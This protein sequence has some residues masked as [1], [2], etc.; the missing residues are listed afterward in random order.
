MHSTLAP[1]D[2]PVTRHGHEQEISVSRRRAAASEAAMA[3]GTL[4]PD[5][6]ALI[7]DVGGHLDAFLSALQGLGVDT[8]RGH[9]PP[10]LLVVQVGDL[11]HRGPESTG[12]VQLADRL[13]HHSDDRY[14][15]LLGNHEAFYLGGPRFRVRDDLT[16]KADHTVQRWWLDRRARLAVALSTAEYGELLVTHAGL[17]A[18]LWHRLGSPATPAAA[19]DQ[20][21]R[22]VGTRP[23]LAFAPGRRLS[24]H[25]GA[26]GPVWADP[27][28]E[29]Y[30]SWMGA[31]PAPFGQVHGHLAAWDW[32]TERWPLDTPDEVCRLAIDLDPTARH[33]TVH[34]NGSP[35]I[36][37]DPDHG[38]EPA[39]TWH[40]LVLTRQGTQQ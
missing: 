40:P 19:A 1:R 24:G 36:G 3:P 11:V 33:S 31:G 22:W 30:P 4:R 28:V 7:G 21:N 26:P 34:I 5:S 35:F 37:I 20:L 2:A 10:G 13:L 8:G 32:G 23:E 39:A 16:T 17:T 18:G 27:T 25:I 38:T 14:I 9:V 12:C 15:Q 29:V 6:V